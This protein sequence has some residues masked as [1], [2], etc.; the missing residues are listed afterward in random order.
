MAFDT[1]KN[2]VHYDTLF[3]CA[4][5]LTNCLDSFT[6]TTSDSPSETTDMTTA[7]IPDG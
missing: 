5:D 7:Q 1:K 4:G 6:S 3:I 2:G